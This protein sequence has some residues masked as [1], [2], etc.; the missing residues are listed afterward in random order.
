MTIVRLESVVNLWDVPPDRCYS[1][2]L[3][4]KVQRQEDLSKGST[5]LMNI[6]IFKE[7]LTD[8]CK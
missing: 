7:Y 1:Q 2:R 4:L 6:K 8:L 3:S 5:W